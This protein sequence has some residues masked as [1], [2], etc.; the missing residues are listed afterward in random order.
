MIRV[1]VGAQGRLPET[2]LLAGTAVDRSRSA[3]R[4]PWWFSSNGGHE[5]SVIQWCACGEM[6]T[7]REVPSVR[8]A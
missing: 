7:E 2:M 5:R 3:Q 4:G 8:E 6:W 1:D